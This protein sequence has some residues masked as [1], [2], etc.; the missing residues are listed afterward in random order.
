VEDVRAILLDELWLSEAELQHHLRSERYRKI[1]LVVEMAQEP[2][3][4]RF[5]IIVRS[6]GVDTIEK[7]RNQTG[8][9]SST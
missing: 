5:D 4:I 6:S 7:A 2:P 9:V 3:E 1:L 8:H